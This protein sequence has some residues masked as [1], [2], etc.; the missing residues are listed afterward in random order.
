MSGDPTQV[1]A[2]RHVR[3]FREGLPLHERAQQELDGRVLGSL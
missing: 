3:G 2:I 1:H